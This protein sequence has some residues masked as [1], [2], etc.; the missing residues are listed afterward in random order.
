MDGIRLRRDLADL[1]EPRYLH[2]TPTWL[3]R[4]VAGLAGV[5]VLTGGAFGYFGYI[6]SDIGWAYAT[7]G[8]AVLAAG[9]LVLFRVLFA[10][11]R[12]WIDLAATA[13]GLY[14][15]GRGKTMVFVSWLDV[16][17]I[18]VVRR[19]WLEG[20]LSHLKF[21]LRLSNDHWKS[22]SRL[23][24]IRGD[25]LVRSYSTSALTGSGEDLAAGIQAT[26][27]GGESG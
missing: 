15:P 7:S 4:V 17:A 27:A 1:P 2:V 5:C 24:R 19:P 3:R 9:G 20:R 26:R 8:L 21:T 23:A 18:S 6:T 22:F 25:S 13:D 16:A 14:L 12:D 11:W 10:D